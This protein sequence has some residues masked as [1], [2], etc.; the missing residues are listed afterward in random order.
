VGSANSILPHVL[1]AVNVS[2]V[3][4]LTGAYLAIRKRDRAT[5]RK[6]M[7]VALC[8]GAAFMILYISYHFGAGLAK[9]GGEGIIRPI[10][11]SVLIIHIFAAAV[12]TPLIPLTAYRALS[13]QIALHKRIALWSWRL[14]MFVAVSG[15]VVYVMTIHL[16]PFRGAP[17]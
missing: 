9:F 4:S 13:D 2:T 3:V 1:A 7:I 10:Y 17:A 11:F 15:L 16:W 5:H 12:A 6:Y 8:F 14:W